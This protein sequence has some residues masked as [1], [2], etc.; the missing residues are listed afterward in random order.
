MN[1]TM[2]LVISTLLI[3]LIYTDDMIVFPAINHKDGKTDK[4]TLRQYGHDPK[5]YLHNRDYPV[6]KFYE[7]YLNNSWFKLL[8][9]TEKG[10]FSLSVDLVA[11]Q[12]IEKFLE[13]VKSDHVLPFYSDFFIPTDDI[14]SFE[15]KENYWEHL[16]KTPGKSMVYFPPDKLISSYQHYK[17]LRNCITFGVDERIIEITDPLSVEA[18]L[19]FFSRGF[20]G[21]S[22][23]SQ[24]LQHNTDHIR[25]K[26]R[27]I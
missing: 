14:V 11:Y 10:Y 24:L 6:T 23:D 13:R 21:F 12:V 26:R 3:G 1:S 2:K 15:I 27:K 19:K 18:L 8:I 4:M 17:K 25:N 5:V 20:D 16:F 9:Q 22:Y 7:D